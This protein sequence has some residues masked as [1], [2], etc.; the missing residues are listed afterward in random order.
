L[1]PRFISCEL[2]FVNPAPL[3]IRLHRLVKCPP[4]E[5]AAHKCTAQDPAICYA[6]YGVAWLS[7]LRRETMFLSLCCWVPWDTRLWQK[8]GSCTRRCCVAGSIARDDLDGVLAR[9]TINAADKTR[10]E[11]DFLEMAIHVNVVAN[12]LLPIEVIG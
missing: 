12:I 11:A 6:E 4:V 7:L 9:H 2:I 1:G 5:L 8:N 10:A 3:S